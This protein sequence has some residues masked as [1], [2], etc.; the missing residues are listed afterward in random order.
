MNL[1]GTVDYFTERNVNIVQ[2]VIGL[3]HIVHL[4]FFTPGVVK[5]LLVVHQLSK[6]QTY[7][8]EAYGHDNQWD[9]RNNPAFQCQLTIQVSGNDD[10][11]ANGYYD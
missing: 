1:L 10:H 2:E 5:F 4:I 7:G 6:P 3:Y 11:N 9:R 8:G